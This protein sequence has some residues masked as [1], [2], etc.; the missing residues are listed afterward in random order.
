MLIKEAANLMNARV[1]GGDLLD[2]EIAGFAFDS[3]MVARDELFFAIS[4]EDYS[5]HSFT[6]ASF[7]DAQRFIPHAFERGAVAAVAH[8]DRVLNDEALRK[9]KDQILFVEDVI[10]ALQMLGNGVLRKWNHPVVAITGSAGKTTTKDLTAHILSSNG[11]RVVKSRKNHNNE[12]GVPLSILQMVSVGQS[13]DL[14]DVAVLEMGMSMGGELTRLTQIAPPDIAVELCV[15]PVHL[16]F[17]GTIEKI[18]EAK[19]ELVGGLKP[20]GTAILNADDK[21]VSAM[22]SIHQGGQGR[23]ITFGIESKADV[24]ATDIETLHLGLT[25]FNLHTP[26]GEAHVELPMPGQHNLMNALAAASVAIS[27]GIK[28]DAIAN[29]LSTAAPSEMRGEVLTFT[30]GFKVVDDSYNSNPRALLSMVRTIAASG[31]PNQR[32]IVIAGEMLELGPDGP[33]LHRETGREIA[34]TGIDVLWGVRGLA[35]DLVEGARQAGMSQAATRYFE[36]SEEAANVIINEVRENDLILV[37]G[38]RG[39]QTDKIVKKLRE[40]YSTEG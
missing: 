34:Q 39:V 37:K 3:R 24:M 12:L 22:R 27:F 13:P 36:S 28:P 33:D 16:E 31:T 1:A 2:K 6:D 20:E 29:A 21:L 38:S 7:Q 26:L 25:K 9:Y 14:F 4:A 17:F 11:R 5:K 23:V 18:A 19:A 35:K 40:N 8:E 10:T 30:A 32:R 15:A